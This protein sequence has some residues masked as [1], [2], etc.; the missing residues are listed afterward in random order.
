[1]T[2]LGDQLEV[3]V[4]GLILVAALAVGAAVLAACGVRTQ[5]EPSS[6]SFEL[7]Y[8]NPLPPTPGTSTLS[9]TP[10]EKSPA[11][12]SPPPPATAGSDA[13]VIGGS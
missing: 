6:M 1:M 10:V 13:A 5:S 4:R 8:I 3:A 7:S 2:W 12:K 11:S 9:S